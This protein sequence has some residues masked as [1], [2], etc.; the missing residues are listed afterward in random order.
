MSDSTSHSSASTSGIHDPLLLTL[1]GTT[2]RGGA[3]GSTNKAK[4]SS[5]SSLTETTKEYWSNLFTK[6]ANAITKPF[7]ESAILSGKKPSFLL[8]KE[9]KRQTELIDQLKNTPILHVK[10]A[11]SNN[12]TVVPPQVVQIAAKRAG[13]LGKP[14]QT[15]AVQQVA[16]SLKSWYDR[17][18]YILHSMTGATLQVD[19][20]TAE[21]AV[22]EPVSSSPPVELIYCREMVIN[23][24]DDSLLTIRQYRDQLAAAAAT[25]TAM[26]AEESVKGRFGRRRR[27]KFDRSKVNTTFIPTEK[28]GRTDPKRMADV[29]G[30]AAG[31]PFVWHPYKWKVVSKRLF[32]RAIR[33]TPQRMDDGTVQLQLVV[34]EAPARHLEYGLSKSLYTDSWEGEVDF[35]HQNLL[36]G[37]EALGI[38]VRRGTHDA[39]PSVRLEL[40]NDHFGLLPRGYTVQL[41]SDYIGESLEVNGE[42]GG[43]DGVGITGRTVDGAIVDYDHDELLDRKGSSISI[44]SPFRATAP[45]IKTTTACL[46]RTSTKGGRHESVGSTTLNLGPV[47]RTLPLDARTSV[48]GKVM[49]GTRLGEMASKDKWSLLPFCSV[50]ATTRQ[51]FPL[52]NGERP[53][54]LALSHSATAST[55]HLPRHEANA[56]GVACKVRGYHGGG[57]HKTS[58]RVANS[59]IGTTELRIPVLHDASVVVFGDWCFS[60][61]PSTKSMKRRSSVGI[62]LRKNVQGFPIKYDISY[63]K[64]HK[65]GAY[66]GLGPDFQV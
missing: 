4:P 62:G 25:D 45:W 44:R 5:S 47:S 41:F 36:G 56:H 31:K 34:Q 48:F 8:S 43:S 14:L 23:S 7:R 58:E 54:V 18:G 13:L 22:Q 49:T 29:L 42:D 19:T 66:F 12:S 64:D 11:S 15:Q 1:A 2:A 27:P 55:S 10:I 60:Q 38:T 28:G 16:Q 63:T 17:Q 30:L 35:Q 32:K 59:L 6:A 65:I 21:L 50:Q 33:A 20:Q 57:S 3:A 9:E 51:T 37:G 61:A 26:T 24:E 39:E 40:E 52:T 53:L 46:E